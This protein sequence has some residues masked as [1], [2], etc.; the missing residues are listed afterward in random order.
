MCTFQV[1]SGIE[2]L[3][4]IEALKGARPMTG[5]R[6]Q[7][8]LIVEDTSLELETYVKHAR[9]LGLEIVGAA[10]FKEALAA[11]E[12][13][14]FDF[15]LTDIHLN[16]NGLPD[17]GLSLLKRVTEEQPTTTIIAMS[18]DPN[19]IICERALSL[20]A[21]HFIRKPLINADELAIALDLAFERRKMRQ[22]LTRQL[23]RRINLPENILQVYPDGLV[24]TPAHKKL[25]ERAAR[26][27][28]VPVVLSGETGTG[29]EELARLLHRKRC[30]IEGLVPFVNVNC[31]NLKE[32]VM[33][34][35]LFGHK[36]GSFAGAIATTSGFVAE[37]DGGILFLDEIHCL[38][39]ACQRMLL[40]VLS[41]GTYQRVGDTATLQ[42]SFQ[43]VCATTLNLDDEVD[44]D[45]F[46]LDLR[47]RLTGIEIHLPALRDRKED[48]SKL[49]DLYFIRNSISIRVNELDK[50]KKKCAEFFWRG[51]IRQLFK[52]LEI[53]IVVSED[54]PTGLKA[55]NLPIFKTMNA[56]SG[57]AA[58]DSIATPQLRRD[59]TMPAH[60][61]LTGLAHALNGDKP[62]NQTIADVEKA[63]LECALTR[64]KYNL[65]KVCLGLQLPRSS[66]DLKRK[67]YEFE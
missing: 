10:N 56:P 59:S 5:H 26:H 62:F 33:L 16:S 40:K 47:T 54:E 4:H 64:H 32:D 15:I 63:I 21:M 1:L 29:K 28:A 31:A 41:D 53:M 27:R 34:S 12:S 52:A 17:E 35:M 60:P 49:I 8:I 66:L 13:R 9:A 7:S 67:R 3:G 58:P 11:I 20:G 55:D 30:E 42:S 23:D 61:I 38:S 46:M 57:I 6:M 48:I 45:R 39:K 44:A 43:V 51:N 25:V 65:S 2:L 24:L 37:A 36:K 22:E 14:V 18:A 50:L 19:S